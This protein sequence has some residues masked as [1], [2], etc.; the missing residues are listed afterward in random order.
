M[1]AHTL[2]LGKKAWEQYLEK[3]QLDAQLV[4]DPV[5]SS[6][7]RCRTLHVDPLLASGGVAEKARLLEQRRFEKEQLIRVA[8][9][10]FRSELASNA[11]VFPSGLC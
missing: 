8:Y 5:A 11:L 3:D 2:D 7:Q 6:W 10:L 9:W 4:R 1:S